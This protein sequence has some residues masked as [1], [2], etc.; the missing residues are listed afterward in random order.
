MVIMRRIGLSL[1]FSLLLLSPAAAD[2]VL[3]KSGQ[4]IEGEVQEKG[5]SYEVKT[6]AGTILVAKSDVARIVKSVEALTAEAEALHAQAR[7]LYEEALKI[8][9]DPPASNAK[10][11]AGVDLLKK[12][13]KL[14]QEA[15]ETYVEERYAKLDDAAVKAIQEMRLYRDKMHAEVVVK[16]AAEPK[17][18]PAV[19]RPAVPTPKP[20]RGKINL[21]ALLAKARAGDLDAQVA[22][23]FYYEERDWSAVEAMKWYKP[24]ADRNHGR[25]L[26]RV[27]LLLSQGRTGK[28]DHAEAIRSF[29]KAEAGGSPFARVYLG[30]MSFDGRG[31]PKDLAKADEWCDKAKADLRKLADDGDPE[32][33]CAMAW[34]QLEGMGAEKSGEGALESWKA[35]GDQD[36]ATALH[37]LGLFY[38]SPRGGAK[39]D[40][41]VK[42][43]HKAAALGHA[44]AQVALGELL[45]VKDAETSDLHKARD[46]YSKAAQQGHPKGQHRLGKM[47]VF[48]KGGVED[49]VE[50]VRLY[51]TALLRA[52]DQTLQEVLNSLAF[53]CNEGIGVK[54]DPR[55]AGKH[56]KAAADLGLPLAQYNMGVFV[57][58]EQNK[59]YTEA[60]K[61]FHLAGKQGYGA[62]SNILGDC[63]SFGNGVKKN[64]DEAEKW[65]LAAVQQGV[66]AAADGLDR[67]RAEKKKTKK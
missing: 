16:P 10:L 23:G 17:P 13:V 3:L 44:E 60:V 14:Y 46:W 57:L 63:Y 38:L 65:Y 45:D 30:Q 26:C 43:L 7:K 66:A 15:R 29:Q 2:L 22:V 28:Q 1:I 56:L 51:R 40:E 62:A 48:G 11:R 19:D 25:A 58:Q 41:A 36:C 32:A 55:E 53:A 49:P 50:G 5:S 54:R 34:M 20:P 31:V 59:N 6:A 4:R 9:D 33:L 21:D 61:W 47:L 8:E 35:A 12:M 18:E 52:T 27:G 42:W 67:V 64:L 24:A 37:Q 39:N